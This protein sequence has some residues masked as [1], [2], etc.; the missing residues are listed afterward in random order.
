MIQ[1]LLWLWPAT[2]SIMLHLLATER[3]R[4]R[5]RPDNL[6]FEV[7]KLREDHSKCSETRAK[8]SY[9]HIICHSGTWG[10]KN[11]F[12]SFGCCLVNLSLSF[13]SGFV[14][15]SSSSAFYFISRGFR[16]G[17]QPQHSTIRYSFGTSKV[18]KGENSVKTSVIHS[19][20]F[21]PGIG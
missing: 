1:G 14:C 7:F 20:F 21:R 13:S 2:T 3:A 4:V 8:K 9:Q 16:R 11:D 15:R 12:I 19:A 18:L 6:N 17:F 10:K 5:R